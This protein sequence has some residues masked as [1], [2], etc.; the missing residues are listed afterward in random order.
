MLIGRYGDAQYAFAPNPTVMVPDS[1]GSFYYV[2]PLATIEPT[3]IRL[4]LP[5]NTRYGYNDLAGVQAE[6][7]SPGLLVEIMV[8][9]A[10]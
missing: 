5:V 6:L 2:R 10:R 1:A 9:A 3:A 7:T 4:G 8:T